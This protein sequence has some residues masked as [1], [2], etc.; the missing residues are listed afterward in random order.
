[1]T[2]LHCRGGVLEELAAIVR[3]G[4]ATFT[5]TGLS[6]FAVF[7]DSDAQADIPQ[8]GGAATP[9]GFALIWPLAAIFAGYIAMKR[10]RA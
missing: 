10:R 1:M 5:V 2:L 6:P 3:D 8:T 9:W 4:K 7:A